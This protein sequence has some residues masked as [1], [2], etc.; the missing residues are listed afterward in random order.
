MDRDMDQGV[1][2]LQFDVAG[3]LREEL[4]KTLWGI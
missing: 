1:S 2:P 4:R 3:W